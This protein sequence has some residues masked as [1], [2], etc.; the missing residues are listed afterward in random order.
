MSETQRQAADE[1][2][3]RRIAEKGTNLERRSLFVS[4]A[5][6]GAAAAGAGLAQAQTAA[7]AAA[8]PAAAPA[9][10]P[11]RIIV[12]DDSRVLN[13]GATVRSGNFWNFTTFMTPVEEFCVRNHYP[14]PTVAQ[15]ENLS[16]QNWKLK[17][18]GSSVERPVELSYEDLLRMP[19]KTIV[20]TM[21]CHGNGRTLFWEQG[22]L[23]RPTGGWRQLGAGR[24]RS[25]R[26][27]V[28]VDV[29]PVRMRGHQAQRAHRALLVGCGRQ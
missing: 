17:I 16:P 18:H 9:S 29:G 21:E 1:A 6:F 28:R 12:K 19:S 14:T 11:R 3:A 10:P 26:V 8:P 2:L 7:P 20:A 4:A 24:H 27:A 15:N 23:H 22:G 25:G 13:I 5:A